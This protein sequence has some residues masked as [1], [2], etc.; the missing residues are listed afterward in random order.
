M[1]GL[2]E[3]KKVIHVVGARPN[4]MKAIPVIRRLSNYSHIRSYLLHTGQHYDQRLS[5]IFF[6]ELNFPCIDFQLK[7]VSA[8]GIA[9]FADIMKKFEKTAKKVNPDLVVVYGDVNSTL[10][11]ALSAKKLNIKVAHVE[12]GLRSRDSSMPEEVNRIL[13]DAVSDLLFTPSVDAN[14][15]LMREGISREKIC[16][17]G[18]VMIDSLVACLPRIH[19]SLILN[20]LN[21]Q[22]KKYC[23]LTLHRPSNVD[24]ADGLEEILSALEEISRN[25]KIVFPVHPRT[26][27]SLK[28]FF[29]HHDIWTNKNFCV[30]DPLGYLDFM[31]L[32]K[33]S[34]CVLT[35]SGGIQ[36]ETTFLGVP[37]LTIRE[38]TER[39][40]TISQGTNVLGGVKKAGIIK[41]FRKIKSR[42]GKHSCKIQYWEGKSSSRIA[43]K[44]NLFLNS[45]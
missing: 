6:K 5:N 35:D 2:T 27:K 28:Y 3:A 32:V 23:V 18:N 4:Y 26:A 9:Q 37:C 14:R 39:P 24:T 20:R 7:L 11:C 1:I 45:L 29:P 15:N 16:F 13:T 33:D 40:I 17:A 41:H 43:H 10:A 12:A 21:L 22:K 34:F 25:Y 19:K 31:C 38:N 36:E 42:S 44:L 8:S 30:I